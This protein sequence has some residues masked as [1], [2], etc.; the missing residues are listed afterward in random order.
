MFLRPKPGISTN[1]HKCHLSGR[2]FPEFCTLTPYLFVWL[3]TSP[4]PHSDLYSFV[5]HTRTL[6]SLFL[7]FFFFSSLPLRPPHSNLPLLFPFPFFFLLS[8]L[9]PRT[10]SRLRERV[11]AKKMQPEREVGEEE[12]GFGHVRPERLKFLAFLCISILPIDSILQKSGLFGLE[13]MGYL[14][15]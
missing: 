10:H 13:I 6:S 2:A 12:M 4:F 9:H 14:W 3:T 7:S 15:I 8:H 1:A 11:S 5:P